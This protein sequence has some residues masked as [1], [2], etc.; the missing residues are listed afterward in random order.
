MAV[1]QFTTKN[2]QSIVIILFASFQLS[3]GS[4]VFVVPIETLPDVV[5]VILIFFHWIGD[6]MIS[7]T[8]NL[9]VHSQKMIGVFY[10]GL[11]GLSLLI[12]L[13]VWK[14]IYNAEKDDTLY[15]YNKGDETNSKS[16]EEEKSMQKGV[17][18]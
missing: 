5:V 6:L 3:V 4:L 18:N 1:F 9:L 8:V 11:A 10:L 15:L 7:I 2:F 16:Q 14:F 17:D 12:Y 13:I